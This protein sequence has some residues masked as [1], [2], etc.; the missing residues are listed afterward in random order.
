[1][2]LAAADKMPETAAPR[3]PAAIRRVTVV[4]GRLVVEWDD[5]A[6]SLL[7]FTW[8]RANCQCATC[9]DPKSGQRLAEI[10][11]V[12][13]NAAP[14]RINAVTPEA[15]TI[16]WTPDGHRSPYRAEWLKEHD[17]SPAAIA[18][19]RPRP[20]FWGAE[21]ADE[22]PSF[23]WLEIVNDP[24]AEHRALTVLFERGF[25]LLTEVAVTNGMV[26]EIGD[27]FGHVRVTNYGRIF[28]VVSMPDPNNLAY[29][30]RALGVHTDNPYRDPPPGI[31]L[32][33]C[34]LAEAPGGEN[35]LVDGIR[36]AESLR[37]IDGAAFE[38]LTR[39]PQHFRFA[40]ADTDLRARQHVIALDFEGNVAGVHF[41]ERSAAPL[42]LPLEAVDSWYAAYR[43]FAELLRDPQGEVTV[44]LDPG[45]LLVM[46]NDRVL[47][48]RAAFDA[49]AGRRH[50][51]GCY[52]DKDGVESRWRML[53][54]ALPPAP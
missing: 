39:M 42:D 21:F 32:L 45:E 8:L 4:S 5:G 6:D 33:H 29:T 51:Q 18:R 34:L 30:D 35:I 28:D 1:M 43:R 9:R 27:R 16:E 40:D 41:N 24:R 12:P 26:A 38:M 10:V 13:L 20:L 46:V 19:R 15:F 47:H 50:L 23:A 11:D 49:G 17:L 52:I 14:R 25:V 31:Q 48:G 36:A 37:R 44:R 7:P 22:A 54:S 53:A 2:S 3:P